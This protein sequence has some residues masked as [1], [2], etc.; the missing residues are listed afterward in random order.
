MNRD[1]SVILFDLGGVLVELPTLADRVDH[2]PSFGQKLSGGLTSPAAMAFE[3]GEI[4]A[5]RFA[6]AIVNEMKLPIS[7]EEL[8]AYFTFWPKGLF[9][10][11][12]GLIGRI[13]PHFSLAIFSNTNELHW[14]RLMTEM[15]LEG[16]FDYYFASFQIRMAKPDPAAFRYVVNAMSCNPSEILFLDDSP[17]NVEAARRVGMKAERVCGIGQVEKI[18]SEYGALACS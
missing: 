15:E 14:P 12:K 9:P 6:D 17:M 3:K 10:G 1:L 5:A 11:T 7:P 13:L 8:L 4:S 16:R 2:D 18:L